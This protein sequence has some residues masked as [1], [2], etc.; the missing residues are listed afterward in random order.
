M[1]NGN[2][3]AVYIDM[4]ALSDLTA[5]LE[6]N[7]FRLVDCKNTGED[8]LAELLNG[9]C[10][11]NLYTGTIWIVLTA[12]DVRLKELNAIKDDLYKVFFAARE[13]ED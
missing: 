9:I 5:R 3:E 13:K 6:A 7:Y 11:E 12:M 8:A 1:K 4:R 2:T 10:D